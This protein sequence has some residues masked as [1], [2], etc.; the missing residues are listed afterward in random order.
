MTDRDLQ[1]F[2]KR[3]RQGVILLIV[4]AAGI[5]SVAGVA[6][7]RDMAQARRAQQWG[8]WRDD[9]CTSVDGHQPSLNRSATIY[10]PAGHRGRPGRWDCDDG[11][12]HVL[13]NSDVPPVAWIAPPTMD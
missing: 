5:L 4:I 7:Q 8:L 13:E 3:Q 12:S 6:F 9:H 11:S 2:K 1:Y 10:T